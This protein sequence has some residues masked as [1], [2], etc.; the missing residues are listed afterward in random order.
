LLLISNINQMIITDE[1]KRESTAFFK[2]ALEILSESKAN[3]LIG[4][5]FAVFQHAG[6]YRNTKDL[7][8]FC[9][10]SEYPKILKSFAAK[11]FK[12]ELTDIRWLAKIRK[13]E[14]FID[15]IFDTVNNICK[16]DDSWFKYATKGEYEGMEVKFL[17]PE[18]LI[19][20]KSYVQNR[21]R[22]DGADINHIIL[23]AGKNMDWKRLLDRLDQHWHILLAQILIFQFVYPADYHDI[24]PKWLFDE[25]ISRSNEQYDLPESGEKVCRGPLIDQT[26]YAVDIK[27]W[28]YKVVTITTI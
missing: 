13:G 8:V 4:G 2:E 25:L 22:F 19:W 20:L 23:K 5:A 1:Q 17:A 3:Y 9:K 28:D 27:Q 12:V 26:Q 16:V 18:E 11:G 24:I 14:Y 10:H 15:V 7:D 21:E 6:I